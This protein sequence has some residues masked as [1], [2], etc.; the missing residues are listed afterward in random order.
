MVSYQSY[1]FM[2]YI[3]FK[4]LFNVIRIVA[5]LGTRL[6]LKSALRNALLTFVRR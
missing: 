5:N 3:H 2:C 1:L 6:Y 4:T